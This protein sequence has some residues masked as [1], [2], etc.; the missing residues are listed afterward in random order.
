MVAVA[1]LFAATQALALAATPT[2]AD[3]TP[4]TPEQNKA[5]YGLQK[6][7]VKDADDF[8]DKIKAGKIGGAPLE[9]VGEQQIVR[10]W[11]H[12][13][14]AKLNRC[15]V[16]LFESLGWREDGKFHLDTK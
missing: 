10:K 8:M 15:L 1:L 5:L 2:F 13:Y 6:E 4:R 11:G 9:E 7:C 14:S 3:N 16:G 12:H